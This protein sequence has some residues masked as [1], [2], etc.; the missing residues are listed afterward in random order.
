MFTGH[1][2]ILDPPCFIDKKVVLTCCSADPIHN[3][4]IEYL[5]ASK[6]LGDILIVLVRSNS[7]VIHTKGYC[8][9]D[10]KDR[11][12]I[13]SA[14]ACVDYVYILSTDI[15]DAVE[16]FQPDIISY[17]HTTPVIDQKELYIC[18]KIGCKISLGIGGTMK[19]NSSTKLLKDIAKKP[20]SE[21]EIMSKRLDEIG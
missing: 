2:V 18:D 1:K 8:V 4:H 11:A 14:L 15:A 10:E 12:R 3:G 19:L 9:L 6:E 17:G 21:I 13:L 16:K 7:F 5:E 20:T